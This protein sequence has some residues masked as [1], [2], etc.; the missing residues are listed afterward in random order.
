V[1]AVFPDELGAQGTDNTGE[2]RT[3]QQSENN[4]LAAHVVF[5]AV[6]QHVDTHVDA[7]SHAICRTELGHPDEHDDAEFLRPAKVE[8][9][10]PVLQAGDFNPGHVAMRHGHEDN[11]RGRPHQE[12][13]QQLFEVVE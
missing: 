10:Q 7:G 6:D 5:E 4:E 9:E 1:S 13:D 11:Q 2:Q 12:S 8:T 3:G